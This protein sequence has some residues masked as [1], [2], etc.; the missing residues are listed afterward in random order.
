MREPWNGHSST[1]AKLAVP[2]AWETIQPGRFCVRSRLVK[3][4]LFSYG[5]AWGYP[6]VVL[7]T[8]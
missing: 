5:Y 8:K 1:L 3:A 4:D 2:K 6:L 7:L